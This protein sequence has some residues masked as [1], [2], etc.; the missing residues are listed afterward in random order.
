MDR[1]KVNRPRVTIIYVQSVNGVIGR[2]LYEDS[3]EWT[4]SEDKKQFLE[5]IQSIGHCVMG[6]NTFKVLGNKPYDGVYH[7]VLSN[8]EPPRQED[9]YRYTRGN[10]PAVLSELAE[11]GIEKVAVLGGSQVYSAFFDSGWFDEV[12]VTLEPAVIDGAIHPTG[13]L[14]TTTELT[15]KDCQKL[16]DRGTLLL[17]YDHVPPSLGL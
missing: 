11:Q 16:N 9:G 5:R 8:I 6:K 13:N 4:S 3:F 12:A 15:L 1:L 14:L 10:I 7:H 2:T 17:T